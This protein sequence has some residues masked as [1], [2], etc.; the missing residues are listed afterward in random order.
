MGATVLLHGRIKKEEKLDAV[1]D[2]ICY[3]ERERFEYYF[4][5]DF[6]LSRRLVLAVQAKHNSSDILINNA[7]IG[8]GKPHWYKACSYQDGYELRLAVNHL[9]PFLPTQLRSYLACRN[10]VTSIIN[11]TIRTTAN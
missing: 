6:H 2:F 10:A 1:R 3:W 11:V 4:I 8:A 5:A 9:A 7:G